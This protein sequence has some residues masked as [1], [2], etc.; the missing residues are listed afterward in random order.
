M[1]PLGQQNGKAMAPVVTS[2]RARAGVLLDH[3]GTLEKY[4]LLDMRF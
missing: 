2:L 3:L 4:P 1:C